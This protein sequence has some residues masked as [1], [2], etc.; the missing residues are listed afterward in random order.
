MKEGVKIHR[1]RSVPRDA[2][3]THLARHSVFFVLPGLEVN[4]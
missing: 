2:G 4:I 1:E 3:L